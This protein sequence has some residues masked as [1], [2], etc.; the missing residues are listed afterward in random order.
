MIVVGETDCL[1]TSRYIG[2]KEQAYYRWCRG[3][4]GIRIQHSR[5]LKELEKENTRL[6]EMVADIAVDNAILI[7]LPGEAAKPV[8][9]VQ[10]GYSRVS[11]A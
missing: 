4:G 5:R 9:E 2:V 1:D 11:V 6:K 7:K 3:Y 10:V 8:E